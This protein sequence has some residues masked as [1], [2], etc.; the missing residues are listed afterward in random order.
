MKSALLP[1]FEEYDRLLN[2]WAHAKDIRDFQ[3]ENALKA[4][5]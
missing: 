2:V 4:S 3:R 1:D 5:T